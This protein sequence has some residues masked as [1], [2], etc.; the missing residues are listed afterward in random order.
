MNDT[1]R[2]AYK[3]KEDPAEPVPWVIVVDSMNHEQAA[4]V[5]RELG[6]KGVSGRFMRGSFADALKRYSDWKRQQEEAV[7]AAE[8]G[9]EGG[10]GQ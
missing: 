1:G 10:R 4:E 7:K 8:G 6:K 2:L 5:G 3:H 9:G